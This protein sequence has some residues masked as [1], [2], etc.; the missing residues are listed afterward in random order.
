MT[1]CFEILISFGRSIYVLRCIFNSSQN[2]H[3]NHVF[4]RFNLSVIVTYVINNRWHHIGPPIKFCRFVT[5]HQIFITRSANWW[6]KLHVVVLLCLNVQTIKS[7]LYGSV[8][9]KLLSKLKS[10]VQTHM[11]EREGDS[12]ILPYMIF[13][14]TCPFEEEVWIAESPL[15]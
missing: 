9:L 3:S 15:L 14:N 1:V 2:P 10:F 8:L 5:K 4:R 13:N 12:L 6:K 7:Q 11:V